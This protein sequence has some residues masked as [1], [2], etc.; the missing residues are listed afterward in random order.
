MPRAHTS[1]DV[2]RAY[3]GN[4]I[5]RLVHRGPDDAGVHV[6][7]DIALGMRR[8]AIIDV[9]HGRQPMHSDDGSLVLVFNGEI[10]NHRRLRAELA[11]REQEL[12]RIRRTLRP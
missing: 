11:S 3:V 4:M 12:A 5:N 1:V 2:L 10:Y 6:T 8:L 7:A 9:A